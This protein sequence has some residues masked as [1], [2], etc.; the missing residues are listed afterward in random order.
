M[1]NRSTIDLTQ[2]LT[3]EQMTVLAVAMREMTATQGWG[4]LVKM[5]EAARLGVIAMVHE[6]DVSKDYISGLLKALDT[7][8]SNVEYVLAQGAAI[9]KQQVEEREAAKTKPL[10]FVRPGGSTPAV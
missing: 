9:A 3:A 7:I 2:K 10:P 6:P 4:Y 5:V 1:G 8:P